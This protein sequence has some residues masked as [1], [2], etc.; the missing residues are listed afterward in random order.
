MTAHPGFALH[1][2]A[3]LRGR[4]G[5]TLFEIVL[6]TVI[7]AAGLAVLAPLL[8]TSRQASIRAARETEAL[9]RAESL[10]NFAVAEASAGEPSPQAIDADGWLDTL[11]VGDAFD[12]ALATLTATSLR[13]DAE[14][15]VEAEVTLSRLVF[16]PS[17]L[18]SP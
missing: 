13:T 8:E 2:T 1:R 7:L 11:E 6:A 12:P 15:R 5:L 18:E 3:V 4:S 10:I 9:N 17:R 14:G 16:V